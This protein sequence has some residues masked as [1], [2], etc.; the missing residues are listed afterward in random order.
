[1]DSLVRIR[2]LNQPEV[3]GYIVSVL[4]QYL[5]SGNI[6]GIASNTG[7]FT[8]IFYPLTS[9]PSGYV[10]NNQITGFATQTFVTNEGSG[11]LAT[12]YA[13]FYPLNSN[14]SGYIVSGTPLTG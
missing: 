3:S 8:G 5:Q 7:V 6:T 11:I 1:M 14:P 9:N 13:S 4:L 10:I 12:A 2:Q